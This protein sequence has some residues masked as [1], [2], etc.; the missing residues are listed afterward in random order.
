LDLQGRWAND[1]DGPRSVPEKE[2]LNDKTGLDGL[3]E[4][5]VVCHEQV[6]ARHAKSTDNGVELIVLDV[7]TAAERCL[8]LFH[9][10]R[11]YRS[12]ADGVEKGVEP[13]GC[14]E[15]MRLGE[16]AL[17]EDGSPRLKLPDDPKLFAKPFVINRR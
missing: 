13:L 10:S 7:D 17:L 4:A 6:R 8:Q 11:R 5:N 2:L 15:G 16:A 12:P 1:E 3:A 9:I 14:I